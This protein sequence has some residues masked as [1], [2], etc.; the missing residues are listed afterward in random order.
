MNKTFKSNQSNNDDLLAILGILSETSNNDKTPSNIVKDKL[1]TSETSDFNTSKKLD[2]NI[3]ETSDFN[4]SKKLDSNISET[5]DSKTSETSDSK[6]S[7]TFDSKILK[8]LKKGQCEK[9]ERYS[10]LLLVF[11][12]IILVLY[13][14]G[15][16]KLLINDKYNNLYDSENYIIVINLFLSYIQICCIIFILYYYRKNIFDNIEKSSMFKYG[17]IILAFVYIIYILSILRFTYILNNI[18]NYR[19]TNYCFLT[20]YYIFMQCIPYIIFFYFL[21]NKNFTFD[22]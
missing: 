10:I 16:Y 19:E 4:T 18:D 22:K 14:F 17:F 11:I 9:K 7:E 2:S 6:T 5:F 15:F 12:I 8:K 13:S 3:S 20:K 21:K 1:K